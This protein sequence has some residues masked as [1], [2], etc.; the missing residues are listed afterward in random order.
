M[1]QVYSQAGPYSEVALGAHFGCGI[2]RDGSVECWGRGGEGQRGDGEAGIRDVPVPVAGL[3]AAAASI[4][5][6]WG[7]ACALLIDGSAYCWGRNSSGQIGNGNTNPAMVP[8]RVAPDLGPVRALSAG[9][10]NTCAV[11][12][13]GAV[14]CWGTGDYGLLGPS[15]SGPQPDPVLIPGTPAGVTAV[16]LGSSH[17]CLL[18]DTG[19]VFC[20]GRNQDGQLGTG[21]YFNRQTPTRVDLLGQPVAQIGSATLHTCAVSVGGSVQCWGAGERG[22][23]GMGT[24]R[25]AWP[26]T[27]PGFEAGITNVAVGDHHTCVGKQSRE[28]FCWGA[29]DRGQTGDD[30]LPQNSTPRRVETPW[31]PTSLSAGTASTCA[32]SQT[33]QAACWGDNSFGGLG[34]GRTSIV[35]TPVRVTH[36]RASRVSS[37]WDHS[38]ALDQSGRIACWGDNV[39]GQLG[40]G[41]TLRRRTPVQ[42][43][44]PSSGSYASL[45]LSQYVSCAVTL[46]GLAECW[47]SN[48]YGAIGDGTLVHRDRPTPVIGLPGHATT[49]ATGGYHSCA[50]DSGGNAH[51]W[52]SDGSGQLGIGGIPHPMSTPIAVN[53]LGSDA[54][55][56]STGLYSTCAVASDGV[57]KCWGRNG[58]GQLGVGTFGGNH[59]LPADVLGI[60]EKALRISAGGYTACALT[61]EEKVKCWGSNYYGQVGAGPGPDRNTATEVTSLAPGVKDVVVGYLH[62]C[63]ITA[64]EG[65][66]C[67][68]WNSGG[69]LGPDGAGQSATP[70]RIPGLAKIVSVSVGWSHSCATRRNGEVL[71]WGDNFRGALGDGSPSPAS[72]TPVVYRVPGGIFRGGFESPGW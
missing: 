31:L 26:L 14:Y 65:V 13:T 18:T 57:A 8:V 33:G 25:S 71:C 43:I 50:L 29:A 68:G 49:I 28:V 52:G 63:A 72:P 34:N 5:A 41:T 54:K 12:A 36:L 53:G 2:T 58:H 39:I 61:T 45:G 4:T 24:N 17:A 3:G 51:C 69:Q 22:Q 42:V 59:Y 44:G 21:D 70:V 56:I 60:P 48:F 55:S 32:L 10:R 6:S 66:A 47:G 1:S 20:W 23:L 38:C 9:P 7:H 46:F 35:T 64:D 11:S 19:E 30:A 37:G 67:W 62:A 16:E 15:F 27:P 40:D